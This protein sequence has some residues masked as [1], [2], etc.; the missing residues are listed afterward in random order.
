GTSLALAFEWPSRRRPDDARA[1]ASRA[2]RGHSIKGAPTSWPLG[3]SAPFRQLFE[4]PLEPPRP[5]SPRRPS[6]PASRGGIGPGP[7]RSPVPSVARHAAR[8]S[9][10]AELP[11]RD[12]LR[13]RHAHGPL[14][15]MAA[16]AELDAVTPPRGRQQRMTLLRRFVGLGARNPP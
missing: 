4:R 2:R 16:F 6:G 14:G 13:S 11:P 8:P 9:Y 3:P 10:V 7:L 12:V 15:R 5:R 1:H